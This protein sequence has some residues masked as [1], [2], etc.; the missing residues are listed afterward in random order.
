MRG[1]EK[2]MEGTIQGLGLWAPSEDGE[3]TGV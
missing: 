1:M 3:T 2:K